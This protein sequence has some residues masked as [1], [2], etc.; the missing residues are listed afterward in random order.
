M[1]KK[2]STSV[3]IV[4]TVSRTRM[5][6]NDIK[7]RCISGVTRG[8]VQHYQAMPQHFI[9]LRTGLTKLTHVA[10]VERIFRD[11]ASRPLRYPG[12]QLLLQLITIGKFG[13][14]ISRKCTRLNSLLP[15]LDIVNLLKLKTATTKIK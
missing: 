5:R 6:L 14:A 2:S 7:I 3:H 1:S 15:K 12:Q 13:L 8:L 11:R 10:I 9:I 4:A